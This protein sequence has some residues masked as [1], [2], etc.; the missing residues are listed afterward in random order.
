G[1]WVRM[2]LF[3][4]QPNPTPVGPPVVDAVPTSVRI[5]GGQ[6][7]VSF[8]T[9]FPFTPGNGRVLVVNPSD[10][11]VNP[12]IG[13]LT[14]VTDVLYRDRPGQRAQFF[15]LEF[16]TNQSANPAPPGRLL[17]F[18]TPA[19]EVVASDLR[20]PVSLAWDESSKSLYVLELSGRILRFPVE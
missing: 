6:L 20:A 1:R 2:M 8:L 5:F 4:P 7:L 14:S 16:S 19:A 10:R 9:G 15:A 13:G 18:D 11:S 17:R 12:F 3:P